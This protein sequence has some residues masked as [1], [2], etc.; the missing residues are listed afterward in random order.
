MN[1]LALHSALPFVQSSVG[2][3]NDPGGVEP[4]RTRGRRWV[5]AT[6]EDTLA[7]AIEIAGVAGRG[8]SM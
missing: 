4:E 8:L 5:V 2:N 1:Q 3:E 7:A 6:V